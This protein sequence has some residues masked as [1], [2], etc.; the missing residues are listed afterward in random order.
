MKK[1]YSVS[2]LAAMI[3]A[4]IGATAQADEGLEVVDLG[5]APEAYVTFPGGMNELG[6]AVVINRNLWDQNI[7]F[8]LLTQEVFEDYDFDDLTDAQYRSIRD[9]LVS[10]TGTGGNPLFQKLAT[11]ISHVF[12]GSVRVLDGFDSLDPETNRLTD[13][14]NYL[15]YDINGQGL[16]VGQ[17]GEPYLRRTT[18]NMDG[19]EV[20][21]FLRDSFPRAFVWQHDGVRFLPSSVDLFQGGTGEAR[22][23]NEANQIVGRAAMANTPGLTN[24]FERCQ[25][26]PEDPEDIEDGGMFNEALVTCVWRYWYANEAGSVA[27]GSSRSPIF[28]EQAHKWILNDNGTIE[29]ILLGG[30]ERVIEPSEEEAEEGAETEIRPLPSTALDINSHGI[31]VGAAQRVVD[32]YDIRD[33][34]VEDITVL[35]S[36]AYRDGEIIPLQQEYRTTN[37]EAMAIND[38]NI[39]VGYSTQR[40]SSNTSRP[41][42]YWVDLD[43][44]DAGLNY[45]VGFFNTS[46]WRPRAINNHNVMV[47]QGEVSAAVAAAR[48]T[49]GFMYDINT[50]VI[51]DL[52][53]LLPCGSDY[54]IVDAYD[55][56]DAGEILALAVT[57]IAIPVDG[58]EEIGGRMRA[59]RLQAGSHQICDEPEQ[60]STRQGAHVAPVAAGLLALFALLITRRRLKHHS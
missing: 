6:E 14:V 50:D 11:E 35:A 9:Y 24:R 20:E 17:A 1:M 30:Y 12:D 31:A 16:I 38:N 37:S 52:N 44:V 10:P 33:N 45:P 36:V 49:V 43:E 53:T 28:V 41:R 21:F 34:L 19:E 39:I 47:G 29:T 40:T 23:I 7:R 25:D 5:T 22:A 60:D 58:D 57:N 13:S 32:A 4:S 8:E 56:N 48:P 26:I 42:A 15:A 55:I 51:T 27:Q 59:V 2:V 18:T 3:A 46:G 54:Q